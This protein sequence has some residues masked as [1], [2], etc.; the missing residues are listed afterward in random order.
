MCGEEEKERKELAFA[1]EG[2]SIQDHK[3]DASIFGAA[4][5]GAV[6]GDGFSV[7]ISTEPE[8]STRDAFLPHIF[9]NSTGTTAR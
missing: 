9:P 8:A 7:P 2:A 5:L 6:C 1:S 4:C 3:L